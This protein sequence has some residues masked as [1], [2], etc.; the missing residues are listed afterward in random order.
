MAGLCIT[1]SADF[2][3]SAAFDGGMTAIEYFVPKGKIISGLL[4]PLLK[5]LLFPSEPDAAL[6][7]I[8]EL[9]DEMNKRFDEVEKLIRDSKTD[10]LNEIKDTTYTNGFGRD[11]DELYQQINTLAA[12]MADNYA[13][14]K[15]TDNEKAVENAFLMGNNADWGKTGNIVFNINRLAN[16]LSG[17]TF[18]ELNNRDLYQVVYDS[19]VKNAMFSGEAYDDS[20]PY[21]NKVM[22]AR[23]PVSQDPIRDIPMRE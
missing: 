23:Q 7:A 21:I 13:S 6:T 22:Y 3:S 14:T 2:I 10:I 19:N 5:K 20:E 18:A 16:V 11:L 1:A 17:Q 12:N 8:N 15:L 9:K 4:K